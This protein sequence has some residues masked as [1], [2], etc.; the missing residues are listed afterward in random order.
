[1]AGYL[2]KQVGSPDCQVCHA[3]DTVSHFLFTCHQYDK[4]KKSMLS[5]LGSLCINFNIK[6]LLDPPK[7]LQIWLFEINNLIKKLCYYYYY[8]YYY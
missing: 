6:V 3:K 4:E 2:L 1:M 5:E 8:Y 7:I